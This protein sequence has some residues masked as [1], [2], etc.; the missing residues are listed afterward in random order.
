MTLRTKEQV[1]AYVAEHD[2]QGQLEAALQKVVNEQ[3][4]DPKAAMAALLTGGGGAGGGSSSI[5]PR[6]RGA[7]GTFHRILTI[8]DCYKLD[9][10]PRVATAI[11]TAKAEAA[12][13]DCVVTSHLNGDF[14]S[15]CSLTAVDGGRGMTE[16][17]NLA[18]IDYVCLGNHEFD[19]G[20]D[21]I[22]T[23]IKQFKGKCVNSN[24]PDERLDQSLTPKYDV[25]EVG[26]KKVLVAGLLTGD[27]SIYAPSNTPKVTMPAEAAV[28]VWDEAKAALGYTP[29]AFLPMT[30]QLIHEDK[31]F[32][33]AIGKH[34]EMG[35]CTPF[36]LAG[37]E[38]DMYVDEGGRST[39]V[40]VGSDAERIGICDVWWD[41]AGKIQSRCVVLP[42]SEFEP[43]P[44]CAKF[45][46]AQHA[47]LRGMM[48]AP[49]AKVD[50]PMTSKKVRHEP[51]GV[52]SF[53]LGYVQRALKKE[54][55][56]MAMVQGGF[57]RAKADY[58]A[59]PFKMGDL[60]AEFA[61]E[62]PFAIIPLKG[63]IIQESTFTTRNAPKPS[64]NFL[65]FSTN[66]ELD[67][68]HKLTSVGGKPFD[69]EA[70]YNVAIYHH[71]LT[72]LNV[73][74]PM[75][76][77]VTANVKVPDVESCRPVKDIVLEQCM[78]DE[79]RALI[80][81]DSMDKDGDGGVSAEELRAGLTKVIEKMDVNG[82]GMIS[83]EEL[84]KYL[85]ERGGNVALVEKLVATLDVDGDGQL[86]KEEF[87]TLLY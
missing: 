34:A 80:D 24:V 45:V 61:F 28:A 23:R 4:A 53:L 73:I 13:L 52:A 14:L 43:E 54:G 33:V 42:S 51:S 30:H 16:G 18:N 19:F 83:K 39:I 71:L 11:K 58:E 35:K 2:L 84:E 41:S 59:G 82:D 69:P 21:V 81:F 26:D 77:Y 1:A 38:H 44:E 64:P 20:F 49:I 17:L 56:D 8:N 76:S 67:E 87:M 86:S 65:H 37:H 5:L 40:K 55:V 6:P 75:M 62:G 47:F 36:V 10:Y 22:A 74:E 12:A 27:T 3:P 15:P 57:V 79:W 68:E 32:A 25:L 9:N 63:T 66:V 85:S 29:D 70:V 60:F 31:A 50:T 7:V 72:G 78:K 46:D 48:S